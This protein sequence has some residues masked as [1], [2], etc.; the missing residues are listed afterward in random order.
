MRKKTSSSLRKKRRNRPLVVLLLLLAA[1]SVGYVVGVPLVQTSVAASSSPSDFAVPLVEQIH[2]RLFELL[3]FGCVLSWTCYSIIG[4]TAMR[5]L[6]PLAAVC[7]SSI[8][9]TLLLL[10]PALQ[11]GSLPEALSFSLTVW[12]SIGYLGLVGTVVGFLWYFEG[13]QS[14]G[15]SRAA[16]FINFVPVNG[17][18][19]ATLLL[20]EQLDISLL[21]GGLLEPRRGNAVKDIQPAF[22]RPS[23][24]SFLRC[25]GLARVTLG[26]PH[27]GLS[28]FLG[29]YRAAFKPER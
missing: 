20:G 16:V 28:F 5:G 1:G 6:T 10:I 9:G 12:C 24:F 21:G 11:Y 2:F 26:F 3:I 25:T 14:I 29:L 23:C 4:K 27:D 15:P 22:C 8:A 7:W 17:V 13:I 19:L 18:L